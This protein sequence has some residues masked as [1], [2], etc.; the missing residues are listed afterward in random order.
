MVGFRGKRVV[1]VNRWGLGV[2]RVLGWG[3]KGW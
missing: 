3:V 2:V 1:G